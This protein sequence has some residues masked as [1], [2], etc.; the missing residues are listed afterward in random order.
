MP[1]LVDGEP[2]RAAG[3][4]GAGPVALGRG[5]RTKKARGSSRGTRRPGEG[6]APADP[7]GPPPPVVVEAGGCCP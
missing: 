7:P 5:A 1:L 6:A 3:A 4:D 2:T